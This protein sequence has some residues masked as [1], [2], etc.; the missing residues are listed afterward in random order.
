MHHKPGLTFFAVCVSIAG[1]AGPAN[2]SNEAFQRAIRESNL[3]CEAIVASEALNSSK[4]AWRVHCAEA[5]TYMA[6]V[7]RD[8]SL[9]VEPMPI[10]DFRVG[11]SPNAS[12][13]GCTQ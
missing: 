7:Q 10:G 9:C 8:G 2:L 4:T 5:A 1:C 12:K 11:P 6:V 13:S 3:Q